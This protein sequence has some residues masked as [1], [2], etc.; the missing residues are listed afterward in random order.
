MSLFPEA[1][2]S[3]NLHPLGHALTT[4]MPPKAL[5][6]FIEHK[7]RFLLTTLYC[8]PLPQVPT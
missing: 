2:I 4:G 1:L 6:A 8:G 5:N 3:L 7:G